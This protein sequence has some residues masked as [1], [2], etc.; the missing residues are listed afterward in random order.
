[1]E[2][3]S[4]GLG[5]HCRYP[6]WDSLI[7]VIENAKNEIAD[8]P[9]MIAINGCAA[10]A[11]G[12]TV[13]LNCEI[14]E[15]L[16]LDI[17]MPPDES[18]LYP[19]R[20]PQLAIQLSNSVAKATTHYCVAIRSELENQILN[21][22]KICKFNYQITRRQI[23]IRE[24]SGGGKPNPNIEANEINQEFRSIRDEIVA[25]V[26]SPRYVELNK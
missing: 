3:Q 12:G 1:M 18:V 16:E 26:E 24:Q 15:T 9:E 8:L 22:L 7:E 13:M 4:S 10:F 2:D 21:L 23:R 6:P 17:F 11:D 25:F 14:S 20:K 19:N 5:D